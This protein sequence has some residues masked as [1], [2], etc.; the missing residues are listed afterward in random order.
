MFAGLPLS[1]DV[2]AWHHDEVERLP[3][4]A[5]VL[6]ANP[7]CDVQAF[8]LGQAVYGLQFHVETTPE[9][10][11][12]WAAHDPVG[13]AS[14]GLDAAEVSARAAAVHPDSRRPGR[15]WP[16]GSPSW[17][18]RPR[19]RER[20]RRGAAPGRRPAGGALRLRGRREG[21]PAARLGRAG[22]VGPRPQREPADPEAA[23]VVSALARA[24]DPD[25]ALL[26]L[27]RLVEALDREDPGGELA[28]HLLARLRGSAGLRSRLLA[29]LGASAGLGDHLVAHPL[30][31]DRAR[32]RRRL[33]RPTRCPRAADAGCGRRRPRRPA[34]GRRAGHPRPGRRRRRC[35]RPAPGLPAGAGGRRRRDLGDAL[36]ADEVAGE[37][38]DLAGAVLVA[39]LAIAV[40]DQPPAPP[41]AGS[42]SSGWASAGARAQLRQRRRRRV[43]GRA[44]RRRRRL[45]GHGHR[46]Q[47]VLDPDAVCHEAAW[48]VDAALRPEG[49]AGQLV[50]T[51]A[52]HVSYYEQWASTG[53]SR[54]C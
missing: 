48:E 24:G 4:G 15:P 45:G 19:A 46:G 30:G 12:A 21:R 42:R 34:V 52:G 28:A 27:D 22:P 36:S 47:G 44:A 7:V 37:L 51:L 33:A 38:A 32:Q 35:A 10:V 2:V 23:P 3:A 1:P 40:A 49:K 53:S 8:R 31:L 17:S 43:R 26:T 5:V 41:R 54:R 39:G 18:A 11:A 13:V 16:A 14:T 29:V 9:M 20:P 50:R 25:L 6:A